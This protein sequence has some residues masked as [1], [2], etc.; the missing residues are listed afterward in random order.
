[1]I[2]SRSDKHKDWVDLA[3]D[4]AKRQSVETELIVIDNIGRKRTIGQCW[5]EGV[6]KAKYDYVLFLGDDDWL[7]EDYCA[8]LLQYA[9]NHPQYVMYTTFMTAFSMKEKLYTSIPRICTGMWRKEYLLKYPFN[10][11]LQKG[12]DREYIEEMQKR[13]DN[14]LTVRHHHGYYYRKHDDYSC[15]GDITFLKNPA[16]IY[17]LTTSRNFIDPLVKEWR[18]HKEVMVS[19]EEFEPEL[20]DQAEIIWC[21]WL[22][23]R[24]VDVANYQCDAKKF[25]RIH[26]Y[27]AFSPLIHYVDFSKFDKVI[28]VADH[29]KDYVE[30]KVGVIPNAVVIPAGVNT[31]A[32]PLVKK[33][34]NNKIAYAGEVSRKKGVDLLF[35]L[36]ES[37][38]EYE[39]HVAGKYNEE[40]TARHMNEMRP[41]NLIAH[42]YQ[43]G[44]LNDFFKDKTYFLN[45][46]LREGNPITLLEA[47]SC[48]LK[49]LVRNWIGSYDIYGMN[50]FRNAGQFEELLK[51]DYNPQQYHD[52]AKQFDF[53]KTLRKINEICFEWDGVYCGATS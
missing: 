1:M 49:P 31:E 10:E 9:Y 4:T 53:K 44:T 7:T 5:N 12:V 25:L 17:V 22:T 33:Q 36:A 6:K 47:M 27:E 14:G 11:T 35:F 2:D 32:Y 16:D 3:K 46:S 40:D 43:H 34:K 20:A 19:T 13:E 39:F 45:T 28:F 52:F 26:A 23:N 15:A 37:F 42:P 51:Q 41:D 48:G 50:V 21:E 38:P 30:H 24:A 29:I 8:V 18:K